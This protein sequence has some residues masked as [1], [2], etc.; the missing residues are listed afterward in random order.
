MERSFTLVFVRGRDEISAV[1]EL[2]DSPAVL[3]IKDLYGGG[4]R[5]TT[6][7]RLAAMAAGGMISMS[8]GTCQRSVRRILGGILLG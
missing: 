4:S 6:G 3:Q 1:N 5:Q 8:T 7:T 2:K